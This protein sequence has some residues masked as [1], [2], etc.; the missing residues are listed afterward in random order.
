MKVWGM[1][2]MV[3]LGASLA[4]PAQEL[5]A[6]ALAQAET[7]WQ[8]RQPNAY[9]FTIALSGAWGRSGATFRVVEGKTQPPR[10]TDAAWQ[11]LADTYGTMEKL[12]AVIRQTL[13]TGDSRVSARYDREYGYPIWADLDPR[14]G[15]TD[16]ERFVRVTG[17][18]VLDDVVAAGQGAPDRSKPPV[19][20]ASAG[21]FTVSRLPGPV[22]VD[23]RTW[24]AVD[25]I[26]GTRTVR[27][28]NGE[29]TLSLTDPNEEGDVARFRLAFIERGAQPVTLTAD[30]VSYAY[31]TN[32]SRWIL[33]E[34]LEVIDVSAWR[35]YSLGKVFGISPYVVPMAIA[36]DGRR[37]IIRR[38]VCPFDC[39]ELPDE[40]YEIGFPP[41]RE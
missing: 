15:R 11:R 19:G 31:V 14:R 10:E 30:P 17:F 36:P 27:A 22:T 32:D 20:D 1:A 34:P 9:Q 18:R 4:A 24:V 26:F 6:L 29:F 23:G 7:R 40:Y 28:P 2:A 5:P 37:L 25:P 33:F 38:Q 12:F 8:A 16:D 41:A 3:L 21:G 39:R 13:A 35:R